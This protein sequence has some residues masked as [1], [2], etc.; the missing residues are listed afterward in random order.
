MTTNNERKVNL[1]VELSTSNFE[2]WEA[3]L[4]AVFY[5]KDT[6]DIYTASTVARPADVAIGADGA[7]RQFTNSAAS[8]EKRRQAYGM[9]YCSLP[10]DTALKVIDFFFYFFY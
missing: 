7:H 2:S 9:I 3:R 5:A 8:R 4:K 1:I 6:Y 10:D